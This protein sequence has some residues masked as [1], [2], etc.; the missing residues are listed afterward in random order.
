MA[1]GRRAG[2]ERAASGGRSRSV[3]F[4]YSFPRFAGFIGLIK[5]QSTKPALFFNPLLPL[6]FFTSFIALIQGAKK[7]VV[8]SGISMVWY[9][10]TVL[11]DENT[12]KVILVFCAAKIKYSGGNFP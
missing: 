2:G 3:F 4:D 11:Y 6:D 5:K 9:W 1:S 8:S 10:G 12:K 7:V